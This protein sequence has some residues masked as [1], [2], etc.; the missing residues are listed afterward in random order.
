M[1]LSFSTIFTLDGINDKSLSQV[2][3]S[4]G[5]F[6]CSTLDDG[7]NNKG[8]LFKVNL[9]GSGYTILVDFDTKICQ[10]IF[11]DNTF[12]LFFQYGLYNYQ[13]YISK[14]NSDGTSY[15]KIYDFQDNI[16]GNNLIFNEGYLF[17]TSYFYGAQSRGYIYKL[18]A[19]GTE[20]TILHNFEG[21]DGTNP[22]YP[23]ICYK[24]YL[25]GMTAMGGA[26]FNG[27]GGSENYATLYRIKTDGS[28]FK[29]LLN[30]D[31]RTPVGSKG[32]FII[33]DNQLYV[34]TY[35]LGLYQKGS[36]FQLSL[37]GVNY[38]KLVD[39]NGAGNGSNP[40][41][42]IKVDD[43]LYGTTY[44][45]GGGNLGTVFS[46]KLTA[47]G[48]DDFH[49]LKVAIYPNP[50]SE[51]KFFIELDKDISTETYIEIVDFFGKLILTKTMLSSREEIDLSGHPKGIYLIRIRSGRTLIKTGKLIH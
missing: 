25:Y 22:T 24:G 44:S 29:T 37:D 35:Q 11:E 48:I 36:L 12:Y 18:K 13:A 14:I 17:G 47:T 30:F 45:G 33:S 46:Y 6:F 26:D 42:L 16:S 43:K 3:Y 7:K 15:S 51:G 31:Q 4:N 41:T 5:T 50:S 23:I 8:K 34:I 32:H 9:D 27:D 39:F 1:A 10:I 38:K 21:L 49:D 19:D 2:F 28:D 20:Y 40:R